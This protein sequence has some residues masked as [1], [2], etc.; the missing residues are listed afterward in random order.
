MRSECPRAS[1]SISWATAVSS[2]NNRQEV[3]TGW[4][5]NSQWY[6][7]REGIERLIKIYRNK[8]SPYQNF[9]F[10]LNSR[11]VESDEE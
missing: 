1:D 2:F 10:N 6:G 9:A 11:F 5:P 7:Y 3:G 4:P 8:K